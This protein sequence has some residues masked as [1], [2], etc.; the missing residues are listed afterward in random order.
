MS[1]ALLKKAARV[2]PVEILRLIYLEYCKAYYTDPI[3]NQLRL[4]C[5][6]FTSNGR[7]Y[8]SHARLRVRTRFFDPH[9]VIFLGDN[10]ILCTAWPMEQSDLDLVVDCVIGGK[11][12]A[13]H[14]RMDMVAVCDRAICGD[15]S[16]SRPKR[17]PRARDVDVS[18]PRA[19]VCRAVLNW[20]ARSEVP[21]SPVTWLRDVVRGRAAKLGDALP[22]DHYFP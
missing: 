5:E 16:Y 1:A 2:L 14:H 6:Y 8:S 19:Y 10:P 12:R 17:D 3:R 20:L 22:F 11:W 7:L 13:R 18:G 15:Y 21:I 4:A 9:Y